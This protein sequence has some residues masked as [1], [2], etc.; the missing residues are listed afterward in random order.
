MASIRNGNYLVKIQV[1][2]SRLGYLKRVV[3][4]MVDS[5]R[6]ATPVDREDRHCIRGS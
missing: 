3:G 1:M 2:G 6:K 5:V 4:L